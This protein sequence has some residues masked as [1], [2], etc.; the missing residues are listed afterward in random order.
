MKDEILNKNGKYPKCTYVFIT[1]R[2]VFTVSFCIPYELN[3]TKTARFP[4][5]KYELL[6]NFCL[7]RNVRKVVLVKR[8]GYHE[9]RRR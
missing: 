5:M 1:H 8:T 6:F 9:T 3:C 4:K 7:P 2:P